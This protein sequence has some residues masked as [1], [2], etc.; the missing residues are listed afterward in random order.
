MPFIH[1]LM[2]CIGFVHGLENKSILLCG[3]FMQYPVRLFAGRITVEP[4][5]KVFVAIVFDAKEMV[6]SAMHPLA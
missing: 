3:K 5:I 6:L 1:V 2:R 4:G